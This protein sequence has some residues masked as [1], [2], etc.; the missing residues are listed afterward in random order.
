M[1][2]F[3]GRLAG[4]DRHADD[5]TLAYV[6]GRADDVVAARVRERLSDAPARLQ[7]VESLRLTVS[8]LRSAGAARAPRS[9]ALREAP[10]QAPQVDRPTLRSHAPALA[11]AAAVVA[12]GVLMIGD[13]AGALR[14]SAG[15]GQE[16][17]GPLAALSAHGA[18]ET[19]AMK[20]GGPVDAGPVDTLRVTIVVAASP[21]GSAAA[22][23][24][25]AAPAIKAA[26]AAV[27]AA[28]AAPEGAD[29]LQGGAAAAGA[30]EANSSQAAMAPNTGPAIPANAAP[31]GAPVPADPRL[32]LTSEPVAMEQEAV[33]G[34]AMPLWQVETGLIAAV[35][36]LLGAWLALRRRGTPS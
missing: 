29:A 8:L 30:P 25:E 17:A 3:F 13:L 12:V 26:R 35:V 16:W 24:A 34:V 15:A 31:A 36:L 5:D 9:F 23:S 11:A 18:P 22:P 2:R 7:D 19:E 20:A 28:A 6:E 33:G 14:Q 27:P 21:P 1:Q 10:A 32:R 4:R